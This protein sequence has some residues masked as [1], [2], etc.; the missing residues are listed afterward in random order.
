[1]RIWV[2]H[3]IVVGLC[4][5]GVWLWSLPQ[6]RAFVVL[7]TTNACFAREDMKSAMELQTVGP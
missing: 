7:G 2:H 5:L 4:V 3:L 6:F 1:M